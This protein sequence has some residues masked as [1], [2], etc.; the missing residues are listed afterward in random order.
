MTH[1]LTE[2]RYNRLTWEEMNE[3]IA[4]QKVVVLPTGSTEQHGLHLPAGRGRVPRRVGVPGV[5]PASRRSCVGAAAGVLRLE[6][7]SHRFSRHD[8]HRAGGLHRLLP[9]HHQE[10]RLPRLPE[11][12]DR[13]RPRL[14]HAAGRPG[15]PQDGAGNQLPL[16]RAQLL[17][18]W[19]RG[20]QAGEGNA[21]D[22]P[23][24]RVRDVALSAS[25]AGA[26]ADGK[27]GGRRR[28]GGQVRE[29]G[30]HNSLSC[31]STTT[32][33]AGP[34]G[35]CTAIRPRP[36]RKRAGSSSRLPSPA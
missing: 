21:G 35:V 13:Q 8:P 14:Q 12:P 25:G 18:F 19:H 22:G 3:A 1:A 2:Y 9:E 23:R 20:V 30:Q 4:A 10:R 5:R 17:H 26:R 29:F 31:V 6:S 11:D 28:C 15:G 16:R 34:S 36:P 33:D 32:G 7:A 27:G 24:R